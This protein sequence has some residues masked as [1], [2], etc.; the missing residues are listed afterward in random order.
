M[1]TSGGQKDERLMDSSGT[2]FQGRSPNDDGFDSDSDD[3]EIV[4]IK[5]LYHAFLSE[6]YACEITLACKVRERPQKYRLTL[7]SL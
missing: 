4:S 6:K 7:Y 3:E 5:F 2:V 1:A